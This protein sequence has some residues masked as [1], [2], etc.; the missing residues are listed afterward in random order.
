MFLLEL[1]IY[2]LCDTFVHTSSL[3]PLCSGSPVSLNGPSDRSREYNLMKGITSVKIRF[4]STCC[5]LP[6]L[7]VS[8]VAGSVF[9]D[10]TRVNLTG[11]ATSLSSV[12]FA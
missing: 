12:F 7:S 4:R 2:D 9:M 10:G 3:K 11:S 1:N 6:V 5:I 8:G